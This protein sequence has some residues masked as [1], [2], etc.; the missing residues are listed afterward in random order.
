MRPIPNLRKLPAPQDSDLK[1]TPLLDPPEAN[2]SDHTLWDID[3]ETEVSQRDRDLLRWVIMSTPK[4]ELLVEIGVD[5]NGTNS[6]TWTMISER[7]NGYYIG[8]DRDN[9]SFIDQPDKRILTIK[10]D[11]SH[12]S[13]FLSIVNDLGLWDIDVLLID[14]WHSV[15]QVLRDWRYADMVRGAVVFHDTNAHPGPMLV[16]DAIDELKWR[17]E[18]FFENE[19]DYGMAVAWR[20]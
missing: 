2:D 17:K 5:R 18:K 14:G 20:I 12:M 8:I 11:S 13:H 4:Q 9:K 10:G 7:G 6:F 1:W 19:R 15:N 3:A 16:F